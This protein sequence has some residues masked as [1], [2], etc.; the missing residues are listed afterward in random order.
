MPPALEPD[1]VVDDDVGLRLVAQVADPDLEAI[2]VPL[3]HERA[4]EHARHR[5]PVEDPAELRQ[6]GVGGD[7]RPEARVGLRRCACAG[8]AGARRAPRS[9]LRR[10][11]RLRTLGAPQ[12]SVLRPSIAGDA[13]LLDHHH[14]VGGARKLDRVGDDDRG[15]VAHQH[16]EAREDLGLALGVESRGGLVEDQHGWIAEQ[17]PGDGDSLALSPGEAGPIGSEH[18]V[19]ALGEIA[20]ERVRSGG[21]GGRDH[22]FALGRDAVGDVVGDRGREQHA[23]LE[24]Q[25]DLL[26]V[27]AERHLA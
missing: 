10:L 23:V 4:P 2:S 8:L 7:G 3:R 1:V 11:R 9:R 18:G 24:Q 25:T 17:G 22:P 13:T 6:P 15:A 27:P 16:V 26:A 20:D 14:P 5:P 21:L 12:Q 19:V